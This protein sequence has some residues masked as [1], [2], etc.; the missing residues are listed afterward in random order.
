MLVTALMLVNVSFAQIS[1]TNFIRN[2][3][4]LNHLNKSFSNSSTEKISKTTEVNERLIAQSEY[5]ESRIGAIDTEIF[6]DSC[7]YG[8]SSDRSSYFSY[9][10]MTY[11]N[12]YLIDGSIIFDFGSDIGFF[13]KNDNPS[14]LS[15][16]TSLYNINYLIDSISLQ[17]TR[18]ATYDTNNN[19]ISYADVY[20]FIGIY[21]NSLFVNTFD[22]SQNI[23]QSIAMS[24]NGYTSTYDTSELR[25]FQYDTNN[26]LLKDSTLIISYGIWQPL[27]KWIYSY[28]D[29]L[30]ITLATYWLYD[31]IS[32]AWHEKQRYQM[33]YYSDNKIQSFISYADSSYGLVRVHLDSFG[34]TTGI[35]YFTYCKEIYYRDSGYMNSVIIYTKHINVYGSPDTQFVAYYDTSG[36]LAGKNCTYYHYDSYGEP[37][38][39]LQY[40]FLFDS[41]TLSGS[42][43]SV[44]DLVDYYYYEVYELRR[45][46]SSVPTIPTPTRTLNVFPNPTANTLNINI[47]NYTK[48]EAVLL[49]LINAAGQRVRTESL[50]WLQDTETFPMGGLAPGVYWLLAQDKAGNAIGRQQVVKE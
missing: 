9:N 7:K 43:D 22:T 48:G 3:Q 38:I 4:F 32:F 47:S 10:F 37:T 36:H 35:N 46:H 42:Y 16:T 13:D 29:S 14:M 39:G 20:P 15:D 40:P 17:E 12:S 41:G 50:P 23:I 30:N 49:T 25:L 18:Y 34:Y 11:Y 21:D 24:Q 2:H 19:I 6:V 28:D 44:P 27:E 5:T 31:S 1:R 45:S 8:Y 26:K 33:T